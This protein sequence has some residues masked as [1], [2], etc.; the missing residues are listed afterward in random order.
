MERRV[1]GT[2]QHLAVS[3][4]SNLE[5]KR[6]TFLKSAAA[7]GAI[8]AASQSRFVRAQPSADG[9]YTTAL[10]GSGWWG[11]NILR[12]AMAAGHSKVVALCDAD[13]D[14]LDKSAAEVT[15]KAGEVPRKYGDYREL[16]E[17]E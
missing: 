7:A 15:S 9:K 6:R 14:Q 1:G 8:I 3:I 12:S 2:A 17:K 16:L 13:A 5:M 10:I 11:M 4:E